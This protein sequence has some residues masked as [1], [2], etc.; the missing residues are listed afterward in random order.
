MEPQ[1]APLHEGVQQNRSQW[2]QLADIEA[3]KTIEAQKA[4][5]EKQKRKAVREQANERNATAKGEIERKQNPNPP[6]GEIG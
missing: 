2:Q 4:V 3:Q 1:L 6:N 5:E